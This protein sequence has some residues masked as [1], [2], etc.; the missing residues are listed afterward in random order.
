MGHR[1]SLW[2]FMGH[3]YSLLVFMGHRY[4][5]WVFYGSHIHC[6]IFMDHYSVDRARVCLQSNGSQIFTVWF[7][8]GVLSNHFLLHGVA[9]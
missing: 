4:S 6:G 5:L 2:V 1:Y 7:S 8:M 3:T 9:R